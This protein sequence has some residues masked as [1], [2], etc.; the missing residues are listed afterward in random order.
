MLDHDAQPAAAEAVEGEGLVVAEADLPEPAAAASDGDNEDEDGEAVVAVRGRRNIGLELD[1]ED[2]AWEAGGDED[3]GGGASGRGGR[4]GE[5]REIRHAEKDV[6]AFELD[7]GSYEFNEDKEHGEGLAGKGSSSCTSTPSRSPS[8]S[9]RRRDRQANA[10]GAEAVGATMEG[11]HPGLATYDSQRSS[12][13]M[14]G[15]GRAG[16]EE[17]A[18]MLELMQQVC[19]INYCFLNRQRSWACQNVCK[20]LTPDWSLAC[21]RAKRIHKWHTEHRRQGCRYAPWRDE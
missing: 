20:I 4:R 16:L 12:S 17:Y 6:S 13:G 5:E 10:A 11:V 19:G 14:D 18:R 8:P 1:E 21:I 2:K 7:R 9:P 15:G 3:G